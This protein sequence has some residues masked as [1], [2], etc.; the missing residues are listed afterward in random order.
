MLNLL[1]KSLPPNPLA[2]KVVEAQNVLVLE[3]VM[4]LSSYDFVSKNICQALRLL[5]LK[6]TLSIDGGGIRL[7]D[8]S[9]AWALVQLKRQ[10]E[11]SGGKLHINGFSEGFEALI[12]YLDATVAPASSMPAPEIK[13]SVF[14]PFERLGEKVLRFF[15]KMKGLIAFQGEIF[16]CFGKLLHPAYRIRVASLVTHLERSGI[17]ALP[18]VGLISFLI[19]IV[20]TFQGSDQLARF[21]AQI[22]TVNLLGISILR[23]VGI[24]L[25]AIVVAGRSGSAFTA[26][27]GSMKLNQ[28]I[29]AL[30]TMGLQPFA[31]LVMPRVV[32][33]MLVMP[34]LAFFADVMGI[35]GGALMASLYLN[36]SF[37]LF[38]HQLHQ[39]LTP[40]TFWVGIIKAPVFAFV[41]GLVGCYEGFAVENK[42]ESIGQHTT[43]SVVEGIAFVIVVDAL[44]S[45]L[46]TRLGI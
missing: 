6:Q 11:A 35:L 32:A 25:T 5:D 3:G 14:S 27:I 16:L 10:W 33:L 9:G 7:M 17:H 31:M 23:E 45:I 43:W 34:L 28:E 18:V 4:D 46:F 19:G 21:G 26:Q 24:L 22:Y 39:S 15:S 13:G 37:E 44:F 8:T 42:A 20:L 29:D 12:H 40:W 38:F 41:I 2:I 1:R 30:E 36:I